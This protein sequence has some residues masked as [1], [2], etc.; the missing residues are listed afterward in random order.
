MAWELSRQNNLD[1]Y[2]RNLFAI[3]K[4]ECKDVTTTTQKRYCGLFGFSGSYIN[5]STAL[6]INN[7]TRIL[8]SGI[9]MTTNSIATINNLGK[10][11]SYLITAYVQFSLTTGQN[12]TLWLVN[13]NT[14]PTIVTQPVATA[15]VTGQTV[16]TV[17]LQGLVPELTNNIMDISVAISSINIGG[18]PNITV[19]S[20]SSLVIS[21]L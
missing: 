4:V 10:T 3:N 14:T 21:E 19:S 9:T 12:M 17:M 2:C 13:P 16:Y 6:N 11:S 7:G 5:S 18:S 15:F 20:N 1:L 8:S